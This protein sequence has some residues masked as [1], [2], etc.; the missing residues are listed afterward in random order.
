M[1]KIVSFLTYILIVFL[2]FS[3]LAQVEVYS[4]NEFFG[5]KDVEKTQEKIITEAKYKKLIK[6]G[7]KSYICQYK[8]KYGIISK[9]GKVLLEPK[10]ISAQRYV[11]KFANL[12]KGSKYGIYDENADVIIAPE[13]DQIKLLYGEM[14]L[15]YKNYKYGLI[16][17]DGDILM[18]PV[19]DD[20][21]MPQSNTI[22][23]K[24]DGTWYEITQEKEGDLDLW[25]NGFNFNLE[26]DNITVSKIVQKPA[27]SAGYGIVS[28]SDYM[29]KLFSSISPAYEETIDELVLN[30]GADAVS[31][32]MKCSWLFKFPYVYTR[33]YINTFKT[34][35]NG[36][37]SEVKIILKNKI[38][39]KDKK[40]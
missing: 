23:I 31:I 2:Q 9:E 29:I 35:N 10:F 22:K 13:Y 5:L 15:V 16:S 37:L 6:L 4:E 39:D 14:F 26:D 1:K 21:Y 36:P 17:F 11:G 34:P 3:C 12:R 24:Y 28:T 8:N 40:D 20:I 33:N 7:E 32:L 27:V 38:N 19:A 25:H 30:N 18:A